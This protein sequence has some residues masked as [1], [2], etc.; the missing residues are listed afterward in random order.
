M[1]HLSCCCLVAQLCPTLCDPWTAARQASL[2]F[3]TSQTLLRLMSTELVMP[4]N[5]L[6]LLLPPSPPALNLSSISVFSSE[7]ALHLKWPKY[8]SFGF[9]ISPS[10]EH[11]GLISFRT[12]WFDLLAVQQ[13]LKS[14][15]QHHSLEASTLQPSAFSIVQVSNDTF[16]YFFFIVG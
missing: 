15:L 4:S 2:S 12:D 6:S 11:S 3:P 13:T 8:W 7:S 1:S 10:S 14:L 5:H 9:S 16:M